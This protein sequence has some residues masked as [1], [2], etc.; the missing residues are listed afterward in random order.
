MSGA[1]WI[2]I[3]LLAVVLVLLQVLIIDQIEISRFIHPQIY[4]LVILGLP[5]NMRHWHSYLFAFLLGLSVDAFTNTPGLNAFVCT[6]LTFLRYVYLQNFFDKEWLA[7]N[8]RLLLS[9]T[10]T[11]SYLLYAAI[12]SVV[13]HLF[14]FLIESLSFAHFSETLLKTLYS[15][16]MAVLLILLL[17]FTFAPRVK[18][19]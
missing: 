6:M 18:N 16:S 4:F 1:N 2:K 3:L 5:V 17:Q 15:S 10:E 7:S 9:N 12:F 8:V 14:Y 13:F 19:E 11:L